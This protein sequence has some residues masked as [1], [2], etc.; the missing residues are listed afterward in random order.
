MNTYERVEAKLHAILTLSALA[1]L[2][3]RKEPTVSTMAEGQVSPRVCLDPVV[4]TKSS[5]SCRES[6]PSRTDKSQS[7]YRLNWVGS[8]RICRYC[9]Y[10]FLFRDWRVH[11]NRSSAFNR[12]QSWMHSLELWYLA[13]LPGSRH[14]LEIKC[15]C[16]PSWIQVTFTFTSVSFRETKNDV[17]YCV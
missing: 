4:K 16:L 9:K 10:N 14:D 2:P 12:W 13:T 1:G 8:S 7:L 6:N 17:L 3:P 15:C 5:C 11:W